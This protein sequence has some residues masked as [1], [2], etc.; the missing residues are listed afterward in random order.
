M[1]LQTFNCLPSAKVAQVDAFG[2]PINFLEGMFT[3]VIIGAE[4][5]ISCSQHCLKEGR[6]KPPKALLEC[7]DGNSPAT[8][9]SVLSSAVA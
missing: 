3:L 4:R 5:S 7:F 9:Q 8:L 6:A 2:Y 1:D